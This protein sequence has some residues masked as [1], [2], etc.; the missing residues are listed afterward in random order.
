MK[1]NFDFIYNLMSE[2]YELCFKNDIT[3]CD[4]ENVIKDYII[5]NC[6]SSENYY[7]INYKNDIEIYFYI[8]YLDN[9]RYS[10]EIHDIYTVD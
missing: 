7:L 10:V 1:K 8:D 3:K 6:I 2:E 4:I 9:F 5:N